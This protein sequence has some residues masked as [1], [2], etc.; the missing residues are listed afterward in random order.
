[1]EALLVRLLIGIGVIWLVQTI[2]E[3]LAIREPARKIIFLI[4]LILAVLFI[5]GSQYLKI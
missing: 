1:M 5:I 2:L 3:T 4:T